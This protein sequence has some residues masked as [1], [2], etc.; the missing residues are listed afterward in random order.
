[1]EMRWVYA[2]EQDVEK[3]NALSQSLNIKPELAQI[4]VQRGVTTFEQA[5]D[6]FRP[7]LDH[8]HDPFLMKDMEKAVNRLTDAVSEGEKILIY[9][10]YDV[11]GT[12]SVAL[13]YSFLKALGAEVDFYIPDRYKEGYGI[14]N[15]GVNWAADNGYTLMVALDCGITAIDQVN[16]ANAL[17]VDMIICDHHNPGA[18][19]PEALAVLDPKRVD[20]NYPFKELSGCGVGF[21]LLHGFCLQQTIDLAALYKYL[22]LLAVSISSDIVRMTDENRILTFYGLKKLNQSPSEGLKSLIEISGL[23]PPI[24]ISDVVF[25]IGPRIN[26]AGRIAHAS[27]SVRL[28][29]AQ[30]EEQTLGFAGQLNSR[31]TERRTFDQNITKEALAMIESDEFLQSSKSTVLFKSDWHKGVV[32]IV[33]SRCIEHYYRPTIILTESNGKATGSARSVEGFDIYTAISSC[34]EWLDQFGGHTHAA[35]LTMPVENIDGFRRAFEEEVKSKL[36]EEHLTPSLNIDL[37]VDFDFINFKTLSIIDQMAPFGPGSLQPTF[38][39]ANVM[40]RNIKVIKEKHLKMVVYQEEFDIELEVIGF[41][42][43]H[44]A[45]QLKRGKPFRLAYHIEENN[46]R[47]NKTL[48]LNIKDIKID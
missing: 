11:D 37:D 27:D 14:S 31:N 47:G 29:I 45:E 1:M 39:S 24:S 44:L 23:K 16:L 5:K 35:G 18:K 28:L 38:A 43:G 6:F 2:E 15:I 8:L 48:Q 41:G 36:K 30:D 26:A 40:A 19:L 12:T 4:L 10:D 32:G 46:F 13:V 21:K 33:A 25:Y 22:D 7:S 20:C 3:V 9:G 34:R 17:N 42:Y